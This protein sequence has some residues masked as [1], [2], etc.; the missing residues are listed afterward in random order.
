MATAAAAAARP[1]GPGQGLL[2]RQRRAP[3]RPL[4]GSRRSLAPWAPHPRRGARLPGRLRR[5]Q[6]G[7]QAC[8]RVRLRRR[9]QARRRIR[10]PRY[11]RARQLVRSCRHRVRLT[12]GRQRVGFRRAA[13]CSGRRWV[14]RDVSRREG[15]GTCAPAVLADEARAQWA[16]PRV[17]VS[18]LRTKVQVQ[19]LIC[20]PT[21]PTHVLCWS[22]QC[23]YL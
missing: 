7:R 22:T 9:R 1:C 6:P 11:G 16:L 19:G 18:S 5:A 17:F 4:R 12:V 13:G 2:H 14:R 10:R 3:Q 23:V 8:R 20:G 15:R 21:T